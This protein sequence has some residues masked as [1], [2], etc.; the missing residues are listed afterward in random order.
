[1]ILQCIPLIRITDKRI[2]RLEPKSFAWTKQV[3][4]CSLIRTERR[5]ICLYE[6]NGLVPW[7]IWQ[8]DYTVYI[9]VFAVCSGECIFPKW[10]RTTEENGQSWITRRKTYTTG[11]DRGSWAQ[12]IKIRVTDDIL[13]YENVHKQCAESASICERPVF[14]YNRTCERDLDKNLFMVKHEA[15]ARYMSMVLGFEKKMLLWR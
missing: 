9:C 1:M 12:Q 8:V 5:I 15:P 2:I 7:W 6:S 11:G 4:C 3:Q 10:L 13:V 14:M